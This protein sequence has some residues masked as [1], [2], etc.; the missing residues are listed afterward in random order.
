M[1]NEHEI[2]KIDNAIESDGQKA[3]AWL[4]RFIHHLPT[5][6]VDEFH[7]I[8]GNKRNP[9]PVNAGA[10]PETSGGASIQPPAQIPPVITDNG[11][12][13]TIPQASSPSSIVGSSSIEAGA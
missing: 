8:F 9:E 1:V 11:A 10:T 12:I 7:A 3:W 2:D 13:Y 6:A 4:V 5:E